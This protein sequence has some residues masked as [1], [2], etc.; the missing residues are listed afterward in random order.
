MNSFEFIMIGNRNI[1]NS[2]I[3]TLQI[4]NS[5]KVFIL[6]KGCIIQVSKKYAKENYNT[7]E[8]KNNVHKFI[9]DR[10]NNLVK[11][12]K[13]SEEACDI[14]LTNNINKIEIV[15]YK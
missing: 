9:G 4:D 13:L 5:D 14:I 11:N 2:Q 1:L 6:Y 10:I 15:E 3:K 7:T 12:N 8:F